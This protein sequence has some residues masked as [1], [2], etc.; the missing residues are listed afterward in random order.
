MGGGDKKEPEKQEE[1]QRAMGGG[2]K[3][4][5]FPFVRLLT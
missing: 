2:D 3:G 5:M 4:E 1:M